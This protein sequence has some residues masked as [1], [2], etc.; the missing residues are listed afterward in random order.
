[1]AAPT[2]IISIFLRLPIPAQ[3]VVRPEW[4]PPRAKVSQELRCGLNLEARSF[5]RPLRLVIPVAQPEP[6]AAWRVAR[7]PMPAP[8]ARIPILAGT[9]RMRVAA[10][11]PTEGREASGVIPG[12]RT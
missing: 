12:T 5:K 2:R 11:E 9:L 8:A 3:W 4:M 7:Q 1:M 10:A 6:T